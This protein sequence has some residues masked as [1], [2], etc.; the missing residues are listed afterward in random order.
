[1]Q[2][3]SDFYEEHK[4]QIE[5]MTDKISKSW[6]DERVIKDYIQN[7][8]DHFNGGR[9]STALTGCVEPYFVEQTKEQ[10]NVAEDIIRDITGK[11]LED[12]KLIDLQI[13]KQGLENR[14]QELEKQ[15]QK[16]IESLDKEEK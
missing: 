4:N 8:F 5:E 16:E 3:G 7:F 10:K 1:M 15:F 14:K 2:C 13:I 6:K 12:L 9:H 11:E